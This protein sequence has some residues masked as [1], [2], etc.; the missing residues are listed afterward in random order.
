MT[1]PTSRLPSVLTMADFATEPDPRDTDAPHGGPVDGP[2]ATG[3]LDTY[4]LDPTFPI[5]GARAAHFKGGTEI[6]VLR[7]GD[8]LA[9]T[10]YFLIVSASNPRLV[11][12]L[13]QE[14]EQAVAEAGG[15]R[16]LRVEGVEEAEWAL[17]DFGTFVVHVFSEDARQYYELERLWGDVPTIE[18]AEPGTPGVSSG[19]TTD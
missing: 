18:W 8:V 10:D 14:I 4:L 15:P 9:I 17:A 13:L 16:P 6:L 3:L 5:I 7:V 11:R 1:R 19:V 12:A 2:A